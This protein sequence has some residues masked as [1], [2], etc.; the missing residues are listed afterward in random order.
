VAKL[1]PVASC[2]P[3]LSAGREPQPPP[4]SR[5][6]RR[7]L[8]GAW[9]QSGLCRC[10]SSRMLQPCSR[11]W[12][13]IPRQRPRAKGLPQWCEPPPCIGATDPNM[14]GRCFAG[15]RS[16]SLSPPLSV[17]PRHPSRLMAVDR[18]LARLGRRPMRSSRASAVADAGAGCGLEHELMSDKDETTEAA[19]GAWLPL[20]HDEDNPGRALGSVVP[21]PC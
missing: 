10:V 8:A 7:L 17:A 14:V 3:S 5:E 11:I 1:T 6:A 13:L 21:T 16:P 20:G 18:S 4:V 15:V 2:V 19:E 9:P 12:K